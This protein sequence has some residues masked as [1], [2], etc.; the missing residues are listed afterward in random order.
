MSFAFPSAS[1]CGTRLRLFLAR[2]GEPSLMRAARPSPSVLPSVRPFPSL[3]LRQCIEPT[4][5]GLLVSTL[6]RGG[7]LPEREAKFTIWSLCLE[8]HKMY[9]FASRS[10]RTHGVHSACESQGQEVKHT[11]RQGDAWRVRKGVGELGG[12]GGAASRSVCRPRGRT[13]EKVLD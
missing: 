1:K 13:D 6:G 7:A 2:A 10:V 3:T 12:G 9:I 11:D 5:S 4:L 8:V